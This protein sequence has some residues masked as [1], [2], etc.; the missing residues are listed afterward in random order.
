MTTKPALL[1]QDLPVN[2]LSEYFGIWSIHG[3][4]LQTAVDRCA[5]LD[6]R[7]HIQQVP[8]LIAAQD[9]SK[10]P[11][12][13]SSGDKYLAVVSIDGP[14]MKYASSLSGGTSTVAIRQQLRALGRDN[15]VAGVLLKVFSPG[16]TVSGN[17]DLAADVRK[18]ATQKPVHAYIEDMGASAAYWIASQAQRVSVNATGLVGSIGTYAVI[19]D[20]SGT[21]EALKLKV[22]V[23]RAGEFKGMGTPGTPVTEE[24]IAELQRTVDSLNEHFLAAVE[25]GRKMTAKQVANLADGRV[26]IGQ[27]ALTLGLVDAVGSQD[28]ALAEL[29]KAVSQPSQQKGKTKMSTE[30]STGPVV[31]ATLSQV[32]QT[33]PSAGADFW[34]AQIE[35]GATIESAHQAFAL[36]QRDKTIAEQKATIESQATEITALK[37]QV[38]TEQKARADAE[39]K[40][41]KQPQQK[42]SVG[43]TAPIGTVATSGAAQ[44]GGGSA[45]DQ[46]N[47]LVSEA[48]SA[49][50]TAPPAQ[51]VSRLAKEHRELHAQM[52]NEAASAS[53]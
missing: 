33:F 26:H 25:N 17:E 29:A 19:E 41:A 30:T 38:E 40:L 32:K 22:H 34:L 53:A 12:A 43:G 14:M 45:R 3:V 35:G 47:A 9:M 50:P 48:K 31:A 15:T 5:G 46:W 20:S 51:I 21:A 42:Q 37:A 23:V 52:L 49:N 6:L 11:I 7:Q 13:Q 24:Q 8:K 27:E 10:V 39:A 4:A 1:E 36:N 18:L 44:S 2:H 16:G 28:D